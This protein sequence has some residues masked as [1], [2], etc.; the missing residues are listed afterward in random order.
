MEMLARVRDERDDGG[1]PDGKHGLAVRAA[2]PPARRAMVRPPR[3]PPAA[4]EAALTR[5]RAPSRPAVTAPAASRRWAVTASRRFTA[6]ACSRHDPI[7]G[8]NSSG[9]RL[10]TAAAGRG[11]GAVGPARQAPPSPAPQPKADTVHAARAA[12]TF[13]YRHVPVTSPTRH[14]TYLYRHVPVLFCPAGDV[15]ARPPPEARR[16]LVLEADFRGPLRVTRR[17]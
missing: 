13:P 10:G 5:S 15:S 2:R 14:V 12:A 4:L 6:P 7:K 8:V 17:P 11:E 9:S 16:R 1:G 3:L